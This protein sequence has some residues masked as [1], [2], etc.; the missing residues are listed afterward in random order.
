MI[1][2]IA[3][4]DIKPGMEA[5]FEANVAR[6][7]EIFMRAKGCRAMELQRSIERPGRYRL[8]IKW[9]T[10]ENH[11]VDFRQSE[12]FKAWRGLVGHCFESTPDVEHTQLC[13]K[14][15]GPG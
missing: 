11:T 5:E 14:G 13:V 4:I 6:A 2:E 7:A 10:L 12:D 9:E 1:L 3:Q 15:F 8:M